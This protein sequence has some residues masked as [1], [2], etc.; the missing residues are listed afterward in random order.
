MPSSCCCFFKAWDLGSYKLVSDLHG[1][2]HWVRALKASGNYLYSGSYKTIKVM[3]NSTRELDIYSIKQSIY[4]MLYYTRYNLVQLYSQ[5][6]DL[7]SFDCVHIIKPN[8]GSVYSLAVTDHYIICGTYE[9]Y[10]NV[11]I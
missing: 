4:E 10:I 1:E 11:S 6:W 7:S 3:N 5:I 2:N 9:N 8:G